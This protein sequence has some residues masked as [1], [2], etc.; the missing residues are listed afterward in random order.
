MKPVRASK[1]KQRL[2]SQSTAPDWLSVA[3]VKKSSLNVLIIGFTIIQLE[4]ATKKRWLT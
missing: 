3:T 4:N 1:L 2:E